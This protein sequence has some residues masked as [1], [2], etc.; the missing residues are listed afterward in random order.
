MSRPPSVDVKDEPKTFSNEEE[1]AMKTHAT[2]IQKPGRD[3]AGFTL[4]EILIVVIL[5][6]I[7]ATIIIPQISVSSDDAKL[8]SLK[9]SLNGMRG[10][11][12]LYYYQHNN[13]Y[14]GVAVPSTQ[15][16]DVSTTAQAFTAQL[17][18]YTDPSGNI[19]N[20]GSSTYA[21]GPYVTG[22]FP[23]NPYNNK[24]DVTIDST[25]TNITVKSSGGAGTGWKFYAKTGVLMAADG[26]HDTL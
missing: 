12:E 23:T 25:E 21:Y 3:Q 24:N 13:T 2:R 19:S 16:G 1:N 20:S 11:V 6:G 15:P 17:S 18:R 22:V 26:S 5:L 9:T 7:L 10:A 8:N 14:P 4:I